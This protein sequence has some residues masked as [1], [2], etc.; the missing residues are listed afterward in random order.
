MPTIPNWRTNLLE[1]KILSHLVRFIG[2]FFFQLATDSFGFAL[3][4]QNQQYHSQNPHCKHCI[5][6][7]VVSV[8][9]PLLVCFFLN[10]L[11][12][13]MDFKCVSCAGVEDLR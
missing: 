7:F 5:Q 12:S 9:I 6:M 13:A 2:A 11:S 1:L 3:P 8:D 10:F 4:L